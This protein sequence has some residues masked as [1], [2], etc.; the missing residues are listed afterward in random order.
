MSL[1]DF[2]KKGHYEIHPND[3]QRWKNRIPGLR[4]FSRPLY[5]FHSLFSGGAM[6]QTRKIFTFLTMTFLLGLSP[7]LAAPFAATYTVTWKDG[8]AWFLD[9]QGRLFLS[10]GVN[11]IGNQTPRDPADTAYD[12]VKNQFGGDQKAWIK[13]VFARL[14]KWHFNTV[15]SW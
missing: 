2:Q 13:N 14:K 5:W 11:H 9:P 8:K 10:M 6:G 7:V 4:A 1:R 12:P 3:C 15:G